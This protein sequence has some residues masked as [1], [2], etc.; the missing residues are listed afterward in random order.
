[1]VPGIDATTKAATGITRLDGVPAGD[2][3][4]PVLWRDCDV[5]VRDLLWRAGVV[6]QRSDDECGRARERPAVLWDVC[7][8]LPL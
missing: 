5:V 1:V 8:E 2:V 4:L 7:V 3:P 6:R